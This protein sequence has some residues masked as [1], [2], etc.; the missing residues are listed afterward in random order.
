M[1]IIIVLLSVLAVVALATAVVGAYLLFGAL[2]MERA[3][4]AAAKSRALTEQLA[5]IDAINLASSERIARAEAENAMARETR[6]RIDAE[7]ARLSAA[8][9]AERE[10]K[11]RIEA[12]GRTILAEQARSQADEKAA[13][14]LAKRDEA[15]S[16]RTAAEKDAELQKQARSQADE[17]AA[18]ALA[19]RDEAD[20]ARTAAE[21]DAELQKQARVQA[22]EKA[23][24]A[25]AKRDEADSART[26]AEKD[27]ELQKQAQVRAEEVARRESAKRV[28]AEAARKNV[29]RKLAKERSDRIA[30]TQI[31]ASQQILNELENL[32][33]LASTHPM[34]SAMV[35]GELSFY[36]E[37]LPDYAAPGVDEAIT[38]IEESLASWSPYG[39]TM[40]Q[41]HTERKADVV[42]SWVRD[43]GDHTLGQAIY[44]T[45]IK[46]GLGT[47]NCLGDWMAF[48]AAT[49]KKI[50]WHELG[51]SMGYGHSQSRMNVMYPTTETRFH[52]DSDL[53]EV[54][55][56]GW[57][58]TIPICGEGRFSYTF[59]TE[60]PSAGFNIAVLPPD[61]DAHKFS[62]EGGRLYSGCGRDRVR[63]YSNSCNV[64]AGSIIYVN[65]RSF[66]KA[67]RLTGQVISANIPPWPDMDWDDEAFRYDPGDLKRYQFLISNYGNL[68]PR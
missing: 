50:L 47:N 7:A 59:E 2:D 36:F 32:V 57:Y 39:A 48:D 28:E 54:I 8:V 26:A 15:D 44:R 49:V 24:S 35:N 38:D 30:L 34:I 55:A 31:M 60:D 43:Y 17:K 42:V 13:S 53:S 52:V 56:G 16:A 45:H 6:S 23:V 61:V 41:V 58:L 67:I 68:L 27:A 22:D 19:K 46:V 4:L 40:I 65:N 33:D 37:P 10:R 21:K 63:R 12:D 9:S 29:E 18:S 64:A 25:L 62:G 14:A 66:T 11:A 5:K 51:H 1:R 20:N 3:N